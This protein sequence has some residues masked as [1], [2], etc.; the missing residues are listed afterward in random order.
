MQLLRYRN[1]GRALIARH[2][3][4]MRALRDGETLL[5]G[6]S[7]PADPRPAPQIGAGAC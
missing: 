6:L 2:P 4:A 5:P 3:G 7:R 1:K